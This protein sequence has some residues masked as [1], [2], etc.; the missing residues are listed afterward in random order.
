MKTFEELVKM[1]REFKKHIE[2]AGFPFLSVI[3]NTNSDDTIAE[4]GF[5]GNKF[6]IIGAVEYAKHYIVNGN[7][8]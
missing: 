8:K 2:E 7:I 3:V 1:Q 6:Q 5:S 4:I